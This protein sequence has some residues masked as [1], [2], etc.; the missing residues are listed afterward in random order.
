MTT[1]SR[2]SAPLLEYAAPKAFFDG[3][4]RYRSA[5][6]VLSA[7]VMAGVGVAL[8]FARQRTMARLGY[9][10]MWWWTAQGIGLL[11]AAAVGT[12]AVTVAFMVQGRQRVV[13]VTEHGVT[14]GRKH[15][16]WVRIARFGGMRYSTGIAITFHLRGRGHAMRILI[17]TPLLTMEPFVALA[18]T[19]KAFADE[20]NT[21]LLVVEKPED[22]PSD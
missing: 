18:Q 20:T 21:H 17:T 8:L 5:N 16:S 4:Y 14:H 7:V 11:G 10:P 22:P 3:A 19:V 15:W 2:E 1:L 6:G 12:A 13:R 9:E